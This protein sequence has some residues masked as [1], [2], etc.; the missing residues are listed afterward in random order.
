MLPT[1]FYN[2]FTSKLVPF[3]KYTLYRFTIMLK[4]MQPINFHS[5]WQSPQIIPIRSK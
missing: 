3:P 5:S 1:F 4:M 2:C